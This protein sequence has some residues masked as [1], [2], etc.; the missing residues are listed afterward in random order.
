MSYYP[1]PPPGF[2][3][4]PPPPGPPPGDFPAGVP[5]YRVT[6][7]GAVVALVVGI[8]SIVL[9][10]ACQP[11]ALVAGGVALFVGLSARSRIGAS[12]GAVAGDGLAIGGVVTGAIG[13]ALGAIFTVVLIGYIVLIAVGVASGGFPVTSPTP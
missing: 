2:G 6:D 8:A 1:P 11:A 7:S 12:A 4:T 3:V 10:C 5:P 13:G 9:L